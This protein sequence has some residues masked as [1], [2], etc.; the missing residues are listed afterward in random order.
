MLLSVLGVITPVFVII[1]AGY[2]S[3][4][5]GYVKTE[6]TQAMGGFIL[7]IALPALVL[8]ALTAQPLRD[9]VTWSYLIAYGG[10]SLLVF[11]AGYLMARRIA[12]Q[13]IAK[14]AVRA[15]GISGSNSG[16]MGYPI[17]AMVIG[18]PAAAILAQ[19]MIFENMI[20]IPMVVMIAEVAEAAPGS[21][22]A[23]LKGIA[24][25][26]LHNPLLITIAIGLAISGSGLHLPQPIARPIALMGAVAGPIALFVVGGTLASLSWG[27]TPGEIGRIV[28]GKLLLHPLVIF[29]CLSVV[30]GLDPVL[31]T[32][33]VIFAA[34]PMAS[35]FPIIGARFG[36]PR[37][38]A[39]ALLAAT[40]TSAA[41]LSILI[42]AMGKAGL[43]S[44]G[45]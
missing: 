45:P 5:T 16:F 36:L 41:T 42:V 35:I 6:A 3:V 28:A 34:V 9:T 40:V 18:P 37:L 32:G 30:H 21:L 8:N 4:R 33:G 7:R 43:V 24:V 15:F 23:V 25:S 44:F 11:T 20:L 22:R 2:V 14:S 38:S 10:G 39:T 13:G 26:L 29:V 1:G 31:V 19:N 12:H 17:A 27:G